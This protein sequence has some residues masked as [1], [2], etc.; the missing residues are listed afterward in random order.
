[1]RPATCRQLLKQANHQKFGAFHHSTPGNSQPVPEP[2]TVR[3]GRSAVS[4]AIARS[5]W[6]IARTIADPDLQAW[7]LTQLADLSDT[8]KGGRLLGAALAMGS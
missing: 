1:L 7:A 4:W 5:T 2:E 3:R 6:E 8:A